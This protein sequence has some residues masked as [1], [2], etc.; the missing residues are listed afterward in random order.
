LKTFW[1]RYDQVSMHELT[2][3]ERDSYIVY[4]GVARQAHN[5]GRGCVHC[6]SKIKQD[7][8]EIGKT[9][10]KAHSSLNYKMEKEIMEKFSWIQKQAPSFG[11]S[12]ENV[13]VIKEP[14]DFH[15]TMKVQCIEEACERAVASG[16]TE[17]EVHILLD[18]NRGSRGGDCSSRTMLLPL[19]EN[20][21]DSVQYL[22]ERINEAIG[23]NHMK[24]YLTDDD[25]I[26]SGANLSDSYFTNRQDRYIQFRGCKSMA[27][28]LCDIVKATACFSF[29]LQDNNDTTY[30][31]HAPHPYEDTDNGHAY[32]EFARKCVTDVNK[33]WTLSPDNNGCD[34]SS[35]DCDT[36]LTPLI[37][38][39]PFKIHDDEYVTEQLFRKAEA[40]DKIVLASGYFNLTSQYLDT[41]L[42]ESKAE[43]E[44]V[45]ASPEANGWHGATGLSH[46]VPAVYTQIA[47]DFYKEVCRTCQ[48]GR[49]TLHEYQRPYWSFH[50]KGLWYY[51]P[52]STLPVCVSRFGMSS[53]CGY[54]KQVITRTV[55]R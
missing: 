22:P 53:G 38:M 30:P 11:I 32:K 13:R 45:T 7:D 37:Q 21:R 27:E 1:C 51:L 17:F 20:Y 23:L 15:D 6:A 39:G 24:I 35:S 14:S 47:H 43:F 8:V 4:R 36:C 26:I 29:H 28:Y 46:Y 31:Q 33:Y 2:R 54:Y 18:Y 12:G 48:Q 44:I 49:I 9:E 5:Q 25:F 42:N 52:H 10:R 41:V 40:D 3:W 55:K 34:N 50:C 19:I 16:N